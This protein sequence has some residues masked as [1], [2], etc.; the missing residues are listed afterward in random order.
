MNEQR[1]VDL[2]VRLRREN[3]QQSGLEPTLVPPNADAAYRIA[4]EVS[5]LLG[6]SVGGWKI[7]AFKPE[8][9]RRLRTKA[10]IFG[11]VYHRDIYVS[12]ATLVG[13]P[14]LHP[15]AEVELVVCM[16]ED[17]LPRNKP[18][19]R[20][21]VSEA[22]VSIRP[23]LEIAECRFV[24]DNNFPPLTAILADGSG[25]GAVILGA[26]IEDWAKR[27]YGSIAPRL[28]VDGKCRRQG[29]VGNAIG[30]PLAP[31]TWLVNELS[32][33]RV[34]LHAGEL[35]STGTLTGM[36]LAQEGQELMGDFSSFGEVRVTVGG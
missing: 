7:A 2:L 16:G 22:V 11:P 27:E 23:A 15:I 10:P 13:R 33:L 9:Q 18:Y 4:R 5:R 24:Y 20:E 34:G 26:P 29:H 1:L 28:L 25:S 3:R 36:F 19:I 12:P 21:E 31:V 17:L 8:M 32:R 6:W 14:L 30:G 35:V